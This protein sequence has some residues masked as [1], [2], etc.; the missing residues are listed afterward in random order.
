MEGLTE[1][2]AMRREPDG[3]EPGPPSGTIRETPLRLPGPH[4]VLHAV[5]HHPTSSPVRR[6]LLIAPPFAAERIF[7]HR[8]LVELAREGAR[9]GLAVVCFDYVGTGDSEGDFAD[10]DLTSRL[11]D[12]VTAW[13]YLKTRGELEQIGLFGFRLGATLAG[14]ATTRGEVRPDLLILA[15]PVDDLGAYFNQALR[16]NIA[17]QTT[18]YRKVI[19]NRR[20]LLERMAGGQP[21]SVVG[22][23]PLG[24]ALWNEASKIVLSEQLQAPAG[25]VLITATIPAS[26]SPLPEVEKLLAAY[27]R[28]GADVH[29]AATPGPRLWD[30]P[31]TYFELHRTLVD[32]VLNRLMRVAS[33]PTTEARTPP[34]AFPDLEASRN[35]LAREEVYFSCTTPTGH[36]LAGILHEPTGSTHRDAGVLLVEVGVGTRIGMHRFNVRLAR[37]LAALG[38]PVLRVDPSGMGDSEGTIPPSPLIE[39][40][41]SIEGGLFTGDLQAIFAAAQRATGRRDWYV[42]GHCGGA[43]AAVRALGHEPAVRG[44]VLTDM[45]FYPSMRRPALTQAKIAS[46][47][48]WIRVFTLRTDYR[49]FLDRTLDRLRRK[50]RSLFRR[51]RRSMP[52]GRVRVNRHGF[53]AALVDSFQT[54]IRRNAEMLLVFS[55]GDQAGEE[56]LRAESRLTGVHAPHRRPYRVETIQD[57]NHTFFLQAAQERLMTTIESWFR[58]EEARRPSVHKTLHRD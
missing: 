26:A 9:R 50:L 7:A 41:D 18:T 19:R 13:R 1:R 37:R 22:G 30:L 27:T 46:A 51:N 49:Y 43:I 28:C 29:F 3:I 58:L 21:V 5:L 33:I 8:N 47:R 16:T 10:A 57:A 24:T 55:A 35:R 48:S 23:F 42:F 20:A 40:Y 52:A 36:A 34:P 12:L 56:F 44:A 31:R 6:G 32:A 15:D 4:G 39:Y 11:A 45:P 17:S 54:M 38:Y 53:N 25:S 2:E 14:L